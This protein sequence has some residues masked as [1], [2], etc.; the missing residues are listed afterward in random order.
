[1]LQKQHAV[2]RQLTVLRK[3]AGYGKKAK[4]KK[5]GPRKVTRLS[6]EVQHQLRMLERDPNAQSVKRKRGRPSKK[7]EPESD[8]FDKKD[9]YMPDDDHSYTSERHRGPTVIE[10]DRDRKPRKERP[11]DEFDVMEPADIDAE[12][13]TTQNPIKRHRL[14]KYKKANKHRW[15]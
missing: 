10:R 13:E 9:D 12:L 7:P 14:L 5:A 15:E 8:P 11:E 3:A 1:M 4:V 2:E 6:P